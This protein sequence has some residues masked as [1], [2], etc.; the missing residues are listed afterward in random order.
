MKKIT[1][2]LIKFIGGLVVFFVSAVYVVLL[3]L[4]LWFINLDDYRN[5]EAANAQTLENSDESKVNVSKLPADD[6]QEIKNSQV[7]KRTISK[8]DGKIL[9]GIKYLNFVEKVQVEIDS[10]PAK[11]ICETICLASWLD[12]E[13]LLTDP[14]LYL[15][16]FYVQNKSR[17]LDDFQF[18]HALES[19]K[20]V[21]AILTPS[22]RE[23]YVQGLE[24]EKKNILEQIIYVTKF[25]LAALQA[26]YNISQLNINFQNHE[27]KMQ[28]LTELQRTCE[29][30]SFKKVKQ[31]CFEVWVSPEEPVL[32]PPP[33]SEPKTEVAD[34]QE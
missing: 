10:I 26:L 7:I 27:K 23:M 5:S 9:Q 12:Q 14:Y 31:S 32:N 18:R 16:K 24:I 29:Y 30:T 6:Q 11:P 3:V 2:V 25:Q 15:E 19:T 28:K 20:V 1:L 17:A 21:A 13:R 4:G 8:D 34:E 33:K 22:M